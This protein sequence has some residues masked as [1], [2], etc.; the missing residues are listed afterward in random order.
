[1]SSYSFSMN[2]KVAIVTGAA[3]GIGKAM[4]QVFADAGAD[5]AAV[6]FD[7]T[8]L[9][10][11]VNEINADGQNIL[12]VVADVSDS[13]Q[14]KN[15]VTHVIDTFGTVDILINN[16][17]KQIWVSLLKTR[18][19]GWD[20][21][22]DVNVKGGYLCA[23]AVSDIMIKKKSGI[24]INLAS[25]AGVLLDKNN[26]TYAAS[27]AAV[28]QMSRAMAGEL[29][30]YGIRVNSIAPG[31]TRTRLAIG[32]I[33]GNELSERFKGSI[34]LGR[35]AEPEEMASVALFLASDAASYIT[36]TNIVVD[37][38]ISISGMGYS[39]TDP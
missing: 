14:V 26:G 2:N 30:P 9:E 4:V 6:D 17:A 27:K 21:I 15:M 1:M 13:G 10:K 5:V 3:R 29:A 39:L 23:Q 7:E 18:E 31:I 19:D 38:G 11:T 16:A 20:K 8:E 28:I 32:A 25:M 37:G 33:E 34:P 24:I 12:K 22:F 35:A 36:G